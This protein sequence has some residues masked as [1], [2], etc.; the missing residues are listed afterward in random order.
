MKNRL[1][2]WGMLLSGCAAQVGVACGSEAEIDADAYGKELQVVVDLREDLQSH[3]NFSF[4]RDSSTANPD[5]NV[6]FKL[7]SFDTLLDWHPLTGGFFVSGG[8]IASRALTTPVQSSAIQGMLS[9]SAA[10]PVAANPAD[11]HSLAPY[12]GLGWTSRN[13]HKKGWALLSDFGVLYRG[14]TTFS[15]TNTN[16]LL[17]NGGGPGVCQGFDYGSA[18]PLQNDG[19]VFP[20][21]L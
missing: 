11:Q 4:I 18:G 10:P 7:N 8:A 17:N 13:V 20:A 16:C 12:L 9:R 5:S 6:D 1:L 2:M 14:R 21:G 19:K 3:F 15:L